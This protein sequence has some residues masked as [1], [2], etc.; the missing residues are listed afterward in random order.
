MTV[1]CKRMCSFDVFVIAF[2]STELLPDDFHARGKREKALQYI[3]IIV[4]Y[5]AEKG[6][7]QI[8]IQNFYGW[9]HTRESEKTK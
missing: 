5:Y 3:A 8:D 6:Y 2:L 9:F 7:E 1:E 4:P